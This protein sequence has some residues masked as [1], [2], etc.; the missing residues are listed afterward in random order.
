[1]TTRS[2]ATAPLG[3]FLLWL[4]SLTRALRSQRQRLPV[5]KSRLSSL[6]TELEPQLR[7]DGRRW[8]RAADALLF[9]AASKHHERRNAA[10]VEACAELWLGIGVDFDDDR[11]ARPRCG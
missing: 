6:T 1:M 11:V 4:V 7:R 10:D 3:G 5:R 9:A 2:G 8:H